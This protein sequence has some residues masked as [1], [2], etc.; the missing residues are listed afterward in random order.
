MKKSFALMTALLALST[1]AWGAAPKSAELYEAIGGLSPYAK[2]TEQTGP[3]AAVSDGVILGDLLMLT[4]AP[5][6]GDPNLLVYTTAPASAT[7]PSQLQLLGLMSLEKL[8][9]VKDMKGFHAHKRVKELRSW[10][11]KGAKP[12]EGQDD[13]WQKG[14]VFYQVLPS[15]YEEEGKTVWEVGLYTGVTPYI[16]ALK[17]AQ[18]LEEEQPDR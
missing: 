6:Q 12:V 3:L 13:T 5:Q 9:G 7:E 14:Q 11:A 1:A 17:A 10:A 4:L 18:A 15:N 8:E 2:I 16:D